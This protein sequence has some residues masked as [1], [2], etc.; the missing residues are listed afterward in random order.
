MIFLYIILCIL[1]Y[2][3]IILVAL[4]FRTKLSYKL[5]LDTNLQVLLYFKDLIVNYSKC[6]VWDFEYLSIALLFTGVWGF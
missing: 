1:D 6:K 5:K 4:K 2:W 3:R